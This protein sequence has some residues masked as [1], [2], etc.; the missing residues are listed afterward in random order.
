TVNQAGATCLYSLSPT[1]RS[2]GAGAATNSVSLTVSNGCPWSVGN[3][4]DWIII[5]SSTA[6]FGNATINYIIPANPGINERTG[7]VAIADQTLTIIQ[8]GA[9]CDISISPTN[10]TH[11]FSAATNSVI[12]DSPVGCSWI[13]VNTNGWLS[14]M[15]GTNGAGSNV[16]TYTISENTAPLDRVGVVMIGGQQFQI[17]QRGV[18]CSLSLSPTNRTHGNGAAT[19]TVAVTTAAGCDW[20]SSNTNTWLTIVSGANG[21]GSNLLTY[22][23]AANSMALERTGS[24]VI[25]DQVFTVIQHAAPCSYT[26]SATTRTHGYG[27]A[28]NLVGLTAPIGCPWNVINTNSWVT[29]TSASSGTGNGTINY[30]VAANPDTVNRTGIVQI[31]DQ[32]L[33]LRQLPAPCPYVL[34]PSN[35]TYAVAGGTGLVAIATTANCP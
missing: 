20:T 8:H 11:G 25:A 24:V 7:L 3:T 35:A 17:T 14:I 13:I 4:N 26:L 16:V 23:V 19:G 15:S 6:G 34:S 21:T 10:R 32:T 30:T 33:T 27:A 28:T 9:A 29:I 2:H 5:T 12:L 31:A 1:S 22:V 18:A